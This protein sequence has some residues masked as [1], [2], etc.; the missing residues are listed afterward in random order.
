MAQAEISRELSNYAYCGHKEYM[1]LNYTDSVKGFE[2]TLTIY[3]HSQDV[4]G[5]IGYLPSNDSIYVTF[6]GST[7]IANWITNL[8]AFK[9]KYQ[10]WPECNCEIHSGFQKAA[11]SVAGQIVAEVHRLKTLHTSA[12]VKTTGHS[13]GAAMAQLT[14][15]MLIKNGYTVDQMITFG[16]PRI[17]NSDYAS[18][19]DSIW[20]TQWRMIHH[21]DIVPHNPGAAWPLDFYHT[22]TE[23]Y[24]NKDSTT[25]KTC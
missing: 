23:I 6:M 17:G 2:P 10:M 14:G 25:Y 16:Q 22:S 13:L 21:K 7:S 20:K 5:F 18:F 12:K 9:S 15:M 11:D 4:E 1:T 8:D 19:S 24:A 3:N